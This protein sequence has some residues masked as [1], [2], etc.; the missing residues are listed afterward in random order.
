MPSLSIVIPVQGSVDALE[1][2]LVSVLENRPADTEIIV[3][4]NI[5]YDDPYQLTDEV[6]FVAARP[7]ASWAECVSTGL[8]AAR[9]NVIHLLAA[10]VEVSE[11]WTRQALTHFRDP[12]V[13]AV[14][15]VTYD[16]CQ[17]EHLLNQGVPVNAASPDAQGPAWWGGFYRRAA[18]DSL[19][20]TWDQHMTP[21]VAATDLAWRQSI[22][23]RRCVVE[24]QAVLLLT[25]DWAAPQWG[26][27]HGYQSA[28]HFWQRRAAQQHKPSLIG[29]TLLLVSLALTGVLRPKKWL[30][31]LGMLA[32]LPAATR[33]KREGQLAIAA[34]SATGRQSPQAPPA[35]HMLRTHGAS[36][37]SELS[38]SRHVAQ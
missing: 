16:R 9:A 3:V 18:L 30:N 14:A 22:A 1:R 20:A 15:P 6:R 4:L 12:K 23:G 32:A 35:P 25:A 37:R 2:S 29:H 31:L 21:A 8:A 26:L 27:R 5:S 19:G 36:G 38:G 34:A 28:R 24:P 7:G 33:F 13:W 17:R 10:G 11:N